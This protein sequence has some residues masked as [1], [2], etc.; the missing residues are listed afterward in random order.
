MPLAQAGLVERRLSVQIGYVWGTLD[1]KHARSNLFGAADF[2]R[3]IAV[4][5][6]Q[7]GAAVRN[8]HGQIQ[9]VERM[10]VQVDVPSHLQERIGTRSPS[11]PR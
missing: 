11:Y 9:W 7:H 8:A 10:Y 4:R 3:V 5:L 1:W 6:T 2:K